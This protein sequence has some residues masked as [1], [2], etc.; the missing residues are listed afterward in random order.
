MVGVN[1]YFLGL[2][3]FCR[4]GTPLNFKV[5]VSFYVGGRVISYGYTG[6][7]FIIWRGSGR[8]GVYF[9]KL[10][11]KLF[12]QWWGKIWLPFANTV[13]WS[14]WLWAP[15]YYHRSK[16]MPSELCM[17]YL[18]RTVYLLWQLLHASKPLVYTLY[19]AWIE[20]YNA[21]YHFCGS[22]IFISSDAWCCC[23]CELKWSL[24]LEE[25]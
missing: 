24:I 9:G 20:R 18:A 22:I 17:Q 14:Q 4:S 15:F 3:R 5:G 25:Q 13:W 10:Q 23:E 1:T 2:A 7:L 21:D 19:N 16:Q 11:V 6:M 8:V 12:L